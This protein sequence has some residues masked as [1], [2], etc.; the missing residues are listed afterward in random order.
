MDGSKGIRVR[1]EFT[2]EFGDEFSQEVIHSKVIP[3]SMSEIDIIADDLNKFLSLIGYP[4]RNDYILIDDLTFEEYDA[5]QDKL[6]EMRKAHK[7]ND[8]GNS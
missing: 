1:F 5:L 6:A 4:R 8:N 3:A 7:E 2:N